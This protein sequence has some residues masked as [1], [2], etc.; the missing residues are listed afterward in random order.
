[1]SGAG[2]AAAFRKSDLSEAAVPSGWL[3]A[4][5]ADT[6][7]SVPAD[8]AESDP[9]WCDAAIADLSRLVELGLPP[10]RLPSVP[11]CIQY[12]A[13]YIHVATLEGP[14]LIARVDPQTGV[15][16]ES[17]VFDGR[18]LGDYGRNGSLHGHDLTYLAN[19]SGRLLLADNRL[20]VLSPG[21]LDVAC[22]LDVDPGLDGEMDS[23]MLGESL[24]VANLESRTITKTSFP[25]GAGTCAG[26]AP[27]DGASP[28]E[29][30]TPPSPASGIA[31]AIDAGAL[32]TCAL[33]AARTVG[34]WGWNG[35]GQ[36][37]SSVVS[38][39]AFP[40][41]V[42]G[43]TAVTAVAAGD[44]HVCALLGDGTVEC[45][46]N[47]EYGQLGDGTTTSTSTAVKVAGIVGATAVA[48]G[49]YHTCAL[50]GDGTVECW[51]ASYSSSGEAAVVYGLTP[52]KVA[53]IVG[54][55]SVAAGSGQTC[56]VLGD[57][58]VRCWGE[59]EYGQLGDGTTTSSSTPVKVAGIVGAT[60]VAAGDQHTCALLGDGSVRC[61]GDGES[62][63]LGDGAYE[64]LW[65]SWSLA[66]VKV[67]GLG[68]PAIIILDF[69]GFSPAVIGTIDEG[70]HT[71]ALTVPYGTTVSALIPT[72][73]ISGASVSPTS[74]GATDFTDPVTYTVTAADSSTQEYV[75]TVTIAA[76][77]AKAVTAFT[78]PTST[79]TV[80]TERTHTIAVSVPYGTVVT[81]LV[82]TIAVSPVAS[83]SPASGVATDFSRPVTY[84]VTAA[85]ASTQDY[86]VT[87]TVSPLAIGD[88]YG[89]GIVAYVDETGLHGLMAAT[90]DQDGG[91]GIQWALKGHWYTAVPGGTGG[92][93]GTDYDIGIGSANT[94]AI[95][96]QNGPGTTY[97][98]GLARAYTG[99]GYTDWY[100]PSSYELDWLYR[101]GAAI[102]GLASA[103]YW[104]S[105]EG[106]SDVAEGQDFYNGDTDLGYKHTAL[107]VRAVRGF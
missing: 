8:T 38:D 3:P 99:G 18:A 65:S 83:V 41:A 51:G 106:N 19:S 104:S 80:I 97:A 22:P 36:L 68:T 7:G 93:R 24:Y 98:A 74:G 58:T 44:D 33:L 87:V 59:N 91:S 81:A 84:T 90:E 70:A 31:V 12:T 72:I 52:V 34:C 45:W 54:A 86:V 89:G 15:W 49:A 21:F 16:L 14:F 13:E 55:T 101:N 5:P 96:A 62:G 20:W 4:V 25:M 76:I 94:D 105:S 42:P 69:E 17:R 82:P 64:P 9:G 88:A 61:W 11:S 39:R 92:D 67:R 85:D 2:P 40:I 71:I 23:L 26:G 107:H 60:A 30:P 66:T 46:G 56:A 6:A 48:A 79:G 29:A 95:I 10:L 57:G 78:T 35:S 75:A 1:M 100:L 73:A 43:V 28:S 102:G 50:L 63:Q 103:I 32:H 37:G 27:G 47:N 77:P 53:G